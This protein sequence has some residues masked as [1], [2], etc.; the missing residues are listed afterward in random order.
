MFLAPDQ[1][2]VRGDELRG[3]RISQMF[4]HAIG[5]NAAGPSE[6]KLLGLTFSDSKTNEVRTLL[7]C[8]SLLQLSLK[9][10]TR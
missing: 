5:K 1:S 4:I 10:G 9:N 8:R 2:L 3:W 6:M 7:I